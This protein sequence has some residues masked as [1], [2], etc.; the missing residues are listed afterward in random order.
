L[1]HGAEIF[2]GKREIDAKTLEKE[3]DAYCQTIGQ[4]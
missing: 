2:S 3:R 4:Q 1:D